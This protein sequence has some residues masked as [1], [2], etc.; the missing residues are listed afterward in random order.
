MQIMLAIYD[1]EDLRML[2]FLR[3]SHILRILV[4]IYKKKKKGNTVLV[5]REVAFYKARLNRK[6]KTNQKTYKL[7]GLRHISFSV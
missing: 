7:F 4:H 3:M 1:F 6:N 2:W 5:F